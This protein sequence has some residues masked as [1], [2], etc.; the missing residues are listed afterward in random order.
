M[1]ENPI[2][3]IFLAI[4]R[5]RQ[6]RAEK[7]DLSKNAIK[8]TDGIRWDVSREGPGLK[9]EPSIKPGQQ[10]ISFSEKD[11]SEAARLAAEIEKYNQ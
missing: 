8:D 3:S 11:K 7:K 9:L 6:R 2:S 10:T 5:A 1:S 4:E